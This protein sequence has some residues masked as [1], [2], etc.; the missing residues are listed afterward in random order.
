[1]R[2]LIIIE[3]FKVQYSSIKTLFK[4]PKENVTIAHY[5]SFSARNLDL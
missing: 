2:F 4:Y 1:M 5:N 3:A